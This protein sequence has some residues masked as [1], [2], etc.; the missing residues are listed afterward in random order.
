MTVFKS[1]NI[2]RVS[3]SNSANSS[4][5]IPTVLTEIFK[6][7]SKLYVLWFLFSH[8]C[9]PTFYFD[10]PKIGKVGTQHKRHQIGEYKENWV[11]SCLIGDRVK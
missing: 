4:T 6:I 2:F 11:N 7:L 1:R 3:K 9:H 10:Y 5:D 8:I